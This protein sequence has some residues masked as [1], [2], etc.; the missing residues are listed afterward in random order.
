LDSLGYAYQQ[1]DQHEQARACYE[2]AV[3]LF[4]KAANRREEGITL[5]RLGDASRAAGDL[6]AAREAWQHA[7]RVLDQLGA[8]ERAENIRAKLDRLAATPSS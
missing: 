2:E 4:R 8:D 1:L 3:A 6:D 5:E 7:A